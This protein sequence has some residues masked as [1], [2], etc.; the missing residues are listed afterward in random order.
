MIIVIFQLENIT[1]KVIKNKNFRKF[2][3]KNAYEMINN[4][5]NS[6]VAAKNMISLINNIRSKKPNEI[7]DDEP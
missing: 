4:K 5:W 2:I 3:S 1:I 6:E 7:N